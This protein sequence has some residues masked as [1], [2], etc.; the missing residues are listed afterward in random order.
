M[1]IFRHNQYEFCCDRCGDVLAAHENEQEALLQAR[2]QVEIRGWKWQHPGWKLYC[3]HCK[4]L[5]FVKIGEE[6]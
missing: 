3:N 4:T 6:N 2:K 1:K 5:L